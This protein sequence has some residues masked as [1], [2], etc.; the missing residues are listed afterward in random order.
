MGTPPFLYQDYISVIFLD[1]LLFPLKVLVAQWNAP[2]PGG[3]LVQVLPPL[4]TE[5]LTKGELQ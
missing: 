1:W 2:F 5:C 3:N 4:L